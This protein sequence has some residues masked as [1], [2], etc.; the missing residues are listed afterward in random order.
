MNL[1]LAISEVRDTLDDIVG[2]KFPDEQIV[3]A[4]DRTTVGMFRTIADG[5]KDYSNFTISLPTTAGIQVLANQWEYRLPHWIMAVIEVCNRSGSPTAEPTYSPYTWTGGASV[6]LGTPIERWSGDVRRPHWQWDGNHTLR[7]VNYSQALGLAIRV[8]VKP[9]PLIQFTVADQNTSASKVN[10][11]LTLTLGKQAIEEGGFINAELQ[12]TSTNA[13]VSTNRGAIR[14][15]IYSSAVAQV[16]G[17]SRT[18]LTF[19][20][21]W[22]GG[23]LVNGDVLESLIAIPSEHCRCLVLKVAEA[24]YQRK[25][26]VAG[27]RLIAREQAEEMAR[28]QAFAAGPR[29][30]RGP[31]FKHRTDR[32]FLRPYNPDRYPPY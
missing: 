22:P 1:T 24:C 3:R 15:V 10:L 4:L 8:V 16:G 13:E 18:E 21:A 20:A 29:D 5:N 28:F 26:N 32:P 11:P 7:L 17:S 2:T 30:R 19:D 25:P 6:S 27:M 31:T 23:A 9:P 12:V 14:R